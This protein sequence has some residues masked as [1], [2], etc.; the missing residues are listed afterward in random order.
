MSYPIN[1]IFEG[2]GELLLKHGK[3]I[4]LNYS[5]DFPM[6]DTYIEY[7]ERIYKTRYVAGELCEIERL[8]NIS[9]KESINGKN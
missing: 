5:P 6:T 2:T 7:G 9:T 3:Q 8:P 4:S 1:D